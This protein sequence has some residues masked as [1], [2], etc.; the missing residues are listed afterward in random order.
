MGDGYTAAEMDKWHADAQRLAEIAVRG[1]RRSRSGAS[2]F[3]VW[4]VDTPS[5]ESGVSR[6]SDGVYR[7]SRAARH[8]RRVRLRALRAGLRQQAAARGGVRRALRVHRDRGERPQVRRRRHPQPLRHRVRRQRVHALRVRARVRPSLR[9]PRPTSTTPRRSP[10]RPRAGRPEPWEPNATADPQAR[11]VEGPRRRAAR[12]CPRRGRRRSSRRR[13][14]R[15]RR[16]AGRSAPRSGPR[17]RWRRS[18]ARSA[19]A[20]DRAARARPARRQGGRVRGRAC[21]RPRATTGPQADCIMFT[22]DEVGFCAVCRRAIE[23]VIDLYTP[24]KRG[25]MEPEQPAAR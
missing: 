4:A 1:R 5:D 19:G 20:H 23:R 14:R 10:T 24:R 8:L 11:E 2:D 17:R 15:S 16:G 12:R 22:R 3:N 6:P 7:R 25:S 21:T 13:R 18:S 9:R